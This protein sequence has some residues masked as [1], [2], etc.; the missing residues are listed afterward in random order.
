MNLFV[1]KC[2]KYLLARGGERLQKLKVLILITRQNYLEQ[3]KKHRKL[4]KSMI[5]NILK[6]TWKKARATQK[7][8]AVR[9][10]V[11]NKLKTKQKKKYKKYNLEFFVFFVFFHTNVCIMKQGKK[12]ILF[13]FLLNSAYLPSTC[14]LFTLL[15][16]STLTS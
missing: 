13:T 8:K 15:F 14:F 4:W 11:Y 5:A 10:H 1:V 6:K 3:Q 2:Y 7:N 9:T 16:Q 12:H